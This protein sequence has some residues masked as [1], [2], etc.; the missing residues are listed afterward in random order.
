MPRRWLTFVFLALV[1]ARAVADETA[2]PAGGSSQV[3]VPLAEYEALKRAQ[4]HASVT[5]VDVLR[6]AGSF[7]GQALSVVFN[8][9]SAGTL[10]SV[11]VL[12]GAA[13]IVLYSCD[14]DGIVSRGQGG[15]F[16]LTPLG[17]RFSVRCRLAARGS[18]RLEMRSTPSV[19]WVESG[20]D[21]GEFVL[22][23]ESDDGGRS[24]AVVRRV[25]V[26]AE[27]LPPSATGRYKITLRP[28]E[29]RFQYEIAV[30]NP[31]RSR[32][33]YDVTLASG[34]HVQQVDAQVPYDVQGA[35]YRF[36]IPPGDATISVSGSLSGSRFSPPIDA[37]VQY[38]VL[39][40]HPLLR[41]VVTGA[42]K[43]VSPQEVGIATEYRGAQAF[44]LSKADAIAW[45]VTRLEALRTTSFAVKRAWHRFF[46]SADGGVLGQTDYSIDNQGAPDISLPMD[47]QPTFASLQGQPVLLTK[48][49]KGDLWLPIAQGA[50]ELVVQH[51]QSFRRLPGL[52]FAALTLPRLAVAATTGTVS[53]HYP[54][55]WTPIYESFLSD[56][57]VFTPEGEVVVAW[58]LLFFWTERMLAALGLQKARR[59]V[60]AV[61][62][63]LAA[64]AW[65]WALA[66]VLLGDLAVTVIVLI[67]W[68]RARKWATGV[69]ILLVGAGAFLVL[70]ALVAIPSLLRARVSAPYASSSAEYGRLDKVQEVSR[71]GAGS[72]HFT[73]P[74]EEQAY[75]GLPAKVEIP[76]GVRQTSFSKEL[77]DT[78]TSR[79]VRVVLVSDALLGWLQ[80]L[81]LLVA[82][83]L[84]LRARREI[85]AG[86]QARRSPTNLA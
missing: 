64:L 80:S 28:D 4:E 9:R 49:A 53:L 29:T 67:P 11:D 63:A 7:K 23:Q 81:V 18:D 60:L 50:Q 32:Q 14:G 66:A 26:A 22:G 5:V 68:L 27:G 58:L 10:P 83:I 36:D 76:S 77:L 30:H 52:G 69:T 15:A 17:A 78:T 79:T 24:F 86:W 61:W 74:V 34:E 12:S 44:I 40:S 51:R 3:T 31:N 37:S 72:P 43:R 19:L 56:A 41:P 8:G 48:D 82:L 55:E 42:S 45:T 38:C 71:G 65:G 35:R 84:L 46:F 39:E 57:R 54:A 20:I 2:R 47:A 70:I 62:L 85:A 16:R 33:A 1:A 6:L 73:A 59:I 21:D 25:T 75:Q 13:G